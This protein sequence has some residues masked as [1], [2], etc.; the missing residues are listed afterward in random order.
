[1]R[2][3]IGP[4]DLAENVVTLVRRDARTKD[5]APTAGI[6]QAVIA[7]LEELQAGLLAEA[8]AFRDERT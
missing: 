4:R 6:S 1:M 3:E 5:T 2:I 7:L 8:T